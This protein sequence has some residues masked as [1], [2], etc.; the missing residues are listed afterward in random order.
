[1]RAHKSSSEIRVGRTRLSAVQSIEGSVRCA[2]TTR[3]GFIQTD[4]CTAYYAKDV[5]SK[6]YPANWRIL[7]LFTPKNRNFLLFFIAKLPLHENRNC[8]YK[9]RICFCRRP[10]K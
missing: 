3:T 7:S 8:M 4:E 1:M 5:Q 10:N 2:E 9:S 6:A